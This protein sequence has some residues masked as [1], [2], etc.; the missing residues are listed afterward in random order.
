VQSK[1][2]AAAHLLD[3]GLL[4]GLD[5]IGVPCLGLV[6]GAISEYHDA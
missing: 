5:E 2:S 3:A 6:Q 1:T 4:A